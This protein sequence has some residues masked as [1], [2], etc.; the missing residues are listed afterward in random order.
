MLTES[1]FESLKRPPIRLGLPDYPT[2]TSPALSNEYYPQAYEIGNQAIRMIDK[3]E[4]LKR[5]KVGR[6]N[7]QPDS[8]F[9]GPF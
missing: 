6:K 8:T 5:V 4:T 3:K 7:D 1:L 2:P 9:Q